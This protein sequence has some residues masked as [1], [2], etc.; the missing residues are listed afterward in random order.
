M[1]TIKRFLF[2]C[3]AA[4]LAGSFVYSEEHVFV[5]PSGS[6]TNPGSFKKPLKTILGAV[7]AIHQFRKGGSKE[8]IT[9]HLASGAYLFTKPL[10]LN[11]SDSNVEFVGEEDKTFICG[12]VKIPFSKESNGVWEAKLPLIDGVSLYTEQL[13]VNGR[14]AV[15]SRY[16]DEGF[17]HPA[18]V[19]TVNPVVEKSPAKSFMQ[20]N[21]ICKP[22]ELNLLKSVKASELKWAQMVIHFKWDTER[23][24]ILGYDSQ[25]NAMLFQG[26]EM[27]SW[28]KWDAK[29]MLYLEN[30]RS[31]FDKPGEWFYD[32]EA[33][34]IFYRPL[35][36]EKRE[37][38]YAW[39]PYPGLN[40]LMTVTG[41]TMENPAE[42]ISFKNIAF[43]YTD[44]P[45][46]K[47]V[48]EASK[49]DV[50]VTGDLNKPGPSQFNA[51]QAASYTAAAVILNFA[52]NITFD[53]C[54]LS[55]L[56]EYAFWLKNSR[57]C[58]ISNCVLT[59]LG[60][61]GVRIGGGHAWLGDKTKVCSNNALY[62]CLIAS[63]GRFH[64]SAV[65]VWIG[66]NTDGNS[67]SYCEITD[68]FYT[69]VSMG[70]NWGYAGHAFNNKVE[71]NKIHKIGQGC[72]ADMGGVYTLG[73][74][75]GSRVCN[76]V[77][78]N[79]ESSSYGG[80]GLYTDEG[81]EGLL[82]ENNLVYDTMDGGFHQHYGKDNIVR[83]N[84]FARNKPNPTSNAPAYQLAASRIEAHR[85]FIFENNI[86]YWKDGT[87]VGYNFDKVQADIKSN[88]WFKDGG[89][90]DFNGKN[91][92]QW[93]QS[94]KDVDGLVA[95]PL[96][97]NPDKNDFRLQPN[98]PAEKIGFKPFDY[99]KAGRK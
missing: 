1:N 7:D 39:A 66:N 68:F 30:L 52:E 92:D 89:E 3:I 48:M 93:V 12:G 32:G 77:I 56:G 82:M 85:S 23:R 9:V 50:S 37:D 46:Q 72:L 86:I 61:G 33:K 90:A 91:H 43:F 80:W 18:E 45:R 96:F 99:S 97:I 35:P 57:G 78:Y 67:V 54:K 81:S 79:V 47:G 70:W 19:K 10:I 26:P 24:I 98:S 25:A 75:T 69:G 60:T 55:H 71:F 58:R 38:A 49:I 27:K 16:P 40:T 8:K 88:L 74:L 6:D 41:E 21:V 15:R 53:N 44:S 94:G 42:K 14:R 28:N 31:A 95:N 62:N 34:K 83:N 17:I 5:S 2:C 65:G 76:N 13:F 20:Y 36:G 64:A 11:R 29:S 4:V 22:G 59:D 84:I 51:G 87:A 63:G 73:T